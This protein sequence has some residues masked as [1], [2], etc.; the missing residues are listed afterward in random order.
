MSKKHTMCETGVAERITRSIYFDRAT[1]ESMA[2][3]KKGIRV[4]KQNKAI[5][6]A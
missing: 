6:N 2:S 3:D 5:K 4:K 1:G